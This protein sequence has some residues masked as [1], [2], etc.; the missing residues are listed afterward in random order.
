MRPGQR[1]AVASAERSVALVSRQSGRVPFPGVHRPGLRG[2]ARGRAGAGGPH[3]VRG[4][5]APPSPVLGTACQE[6][7]LRLSAAFSILLPSSLREHGILLGFSLQN[8]GASWSWESLSP[9]QHASLPKRC[10]AA[11][12]IAQEMGLSSCCTDVLPYLVNLSP[13]GGLWL[14]FCWQ[15]EVCGAYPLAYRQIHK[16][17]CCFILIIKAR[18][19]LLPHTVP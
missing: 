17:F 11:C 15:W 13:T 9:P 10:S 2:R 12:R 18:P 5:W 19:L 14:A 6:G 8:T 7:A 4:C 16:V 1:Q 3:A